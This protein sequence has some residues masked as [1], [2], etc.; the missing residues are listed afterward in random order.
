MAFINPV[1]AIH[2]KANNGRSIGAHV[3]QVGEDGTKNCYRAEASVDSVRMAH[4]HHDDRD[5][6]KTWAEGM[7]G[8][9]MEVHSGPAEIAPDDDK[10]APEVKKWIVQDWAGN[11]MYPDREFDGFE[12]GWEFVRTDHPDEKDWEDIYVVPKDGKGTGE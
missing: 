4:S 10:P 8:S 5:S 9:Y 2:E 12:D 3:H 11:R 7:A 1:M 6:A